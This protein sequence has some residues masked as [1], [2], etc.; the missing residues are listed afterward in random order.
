[1]EELPQ[2]KKLENKELNMINTMQTLIYDTFN[3]LK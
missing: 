3:L 2:E 1:M